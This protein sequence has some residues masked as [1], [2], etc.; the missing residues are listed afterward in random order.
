MYIAYSPF[1]YYRYI[2]LNDAIKYCELN[3]GFLIRYSSMDLFP[4]YSTEWEKEYK[5]NEYLLFIL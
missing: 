2:N 5:T 3:N 4:S 1:G